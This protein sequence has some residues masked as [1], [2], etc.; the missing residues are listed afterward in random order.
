MYSFRMLTLN[1]QYKNL[2]NYI[3]INMSLFM[4]NSYNMKTNI[5]NHN[6][7]MILRFC[8]IQ[9]VLNMNNYISINIYFKLSIIIKIEI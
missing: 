3:M 5:Y 1:I 9:L 7:L 4:I 6:I 2:Y 8:V